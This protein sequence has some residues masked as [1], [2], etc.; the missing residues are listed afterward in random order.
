MKANPSQETR[1]FVD[2][3]RL[4]DFVLFTQR[5]CILNLSGKL[6]SGNVSFPQFFLLAYLSSEEY[7]TM[8]DIAKKMGHST[9]ATTG[10]VDRLE[11]LGYVERVHAAEDRRKIMVRITHKGT[12]LVAQ[13]R[14][15]IASNLSTLMAEMDEEEAET[16]TH[17]D[18]AIAGKIL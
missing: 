14:E 10:L 7:L 16:V 15:E 2:T 3:N 4:A 6:N 8:S 17:A 11:K 1:P 18:R 5:S 9:A 12:E 13:M